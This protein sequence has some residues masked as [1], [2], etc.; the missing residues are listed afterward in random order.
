MTWTGHGCAK[1][2]SGVNRR[3]SQNRED[4]GDPAGLTRRVRVPRRVKCYDDLWDTGA[5]GT[6]TSV[7]T[8]PCQE[9]F[10]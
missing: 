5:E 4:I 6:N 9:Q 10:C 2:K 8:C 3:L 1:S 7:I